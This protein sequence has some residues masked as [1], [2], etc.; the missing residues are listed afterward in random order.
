M[1]ACQALQQPSLAFITR[2]ACIDSH[3]HLPCGH[4][5]MGASSSRG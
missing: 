5:S 1:H 4:I 3:M 2:Q